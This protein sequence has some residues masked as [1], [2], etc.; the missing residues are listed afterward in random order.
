MKLNLKAFTLTAAIGWG[1][2][3]LLVGL[4][5]LI[6]PPYGDAWLH[7]GQSIY[8]GYHGPGGFGSVIVVTLYALLDGAVGGAVFAWLY[9][10]FAG[11]N[12]GA[13]QP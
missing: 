12:G 4:A 1:G 3:F 11:A 10:L 9:N 13:S 2:C 6:W 7:L 8:P 5:N